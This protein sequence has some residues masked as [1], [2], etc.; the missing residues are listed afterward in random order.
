[1]VYMLI[2]CETGVSHYSKI[3]CG[4]AQFPNSKH[5][6]LKLATLVKHARCQQSILITSILMTSNVNQCESQRM[7]KYME[8]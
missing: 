3:N 4:K 7:G 1:M 5:T 8:K 2:V 6:Q